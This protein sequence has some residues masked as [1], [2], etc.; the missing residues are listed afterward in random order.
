MLNQLPT[1]RPGMPGLPMSP[2]KP[3]GPGGPNSPWK[4]DRYAMTYRRGVILAWFIS[5]IY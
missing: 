4:T 3:G 2:L 5:S 1:G